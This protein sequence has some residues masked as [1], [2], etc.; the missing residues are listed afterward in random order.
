MWTVYKMAGLVLLEG[1]FFSTRYRGSHYLNKFADLEQD[2]EHQVSP[3]ARSTGVQYVIAVVR[4]DLLT[5]FLYFFLLSV[6][7]SSS[8][9][10]T[11]SGGISHQ[12]GTWKYHHAGPLEASSHGFQ[13]YCRQ[14]MFRSGVLQNRHQYVAQGAQGEDF[15]RVAEQVP[16]IFRTTGDSG[17]AEEFMRKTPLSAYPSA[18]RDRKVDSQHLSWEHEAFSP[19]RGSTPCAVR[20]WIKKKLRL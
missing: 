10:T 3:H 13:K 15:S 8:R 19:H 7:H 17:S 9:P 18:R 4:V 2:R 14:R 1:L 12:V 5:F 20:L 6:R 16:T 11:L